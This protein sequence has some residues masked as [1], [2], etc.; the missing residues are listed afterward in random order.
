M[1]LAKESVG[2]VPGTGEGW[3]GAWHRRGF[4][5]CLAERKGLAV[6]LAEDT[7]P[8]PLPAHAVP[9]RAGVNTGFSRKSS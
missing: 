8:A 5:V 2:K 7:G 4:V 3:Q 6:L 1:C 9:G